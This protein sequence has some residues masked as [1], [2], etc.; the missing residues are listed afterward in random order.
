MPSFS[1][2]YKGYLKGECKDYKQSLIDALKGMKKEEKM[3]NKGRL[4]KMKD[5]K[6]KCMQCDG[7]RVAGSSLCI[8]C[9]KSLLDPAEISNRRLIYQIKER[10]EKIKK[11]TAL[12]E[13]LLEQ[14]MDN[15]DEHARRSI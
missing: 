4:D 14:I 5:E 2:E 15:A 3:R 12:C 10:D 6:G 9:L 8:D 1:K 13:K 7:V 11:L